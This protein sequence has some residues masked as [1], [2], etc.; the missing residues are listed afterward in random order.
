MIPDW[1]QFDSLSEWK[2]DG[3]VDQNKEYNYIYNLH[4]VPIMDFTETF[5]QI[6][7]PSNDYF[8]NG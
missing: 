7:V 5:T 6:R 4:A 8:A 3:R 1:E 2:Y